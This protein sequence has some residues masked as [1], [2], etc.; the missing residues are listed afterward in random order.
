MAG[1]PPAATTRPER[2]TVPDDGWHEVPG[3]VMLSVGTPSGW[4]SVADMTDGLSC[5]RPEDGR[6]NRKER[7]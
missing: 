1:P 7:L 6:L 5:P 3:M 2:T 4:P